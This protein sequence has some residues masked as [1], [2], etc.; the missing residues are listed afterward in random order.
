VVIIILQI[1]TILDL[2]VISSITVH[3][4]FLKKEDS[5]WRLRKLGEC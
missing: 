5:L 3:F 1:I 2:D 4:L